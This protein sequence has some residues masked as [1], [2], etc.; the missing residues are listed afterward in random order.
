VHF[1]VISFQ[2]FISTYSIAKGGE[3]MLCGCRNISHRRR[4]LEK[5]SII[6]SKNSDIII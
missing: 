1:P 3:N 5:V 6:I 4:I 2:E